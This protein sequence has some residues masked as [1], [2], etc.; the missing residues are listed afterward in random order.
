MSDPKTLLIVGGV[1]GGASAAARARR[2]S[3]SCR[4]VVFD[5]GPYVSFANCGLPYYVGDVIRDE[6][7][8]LVASEALFRNRFE[9]E[10][11]TRNEVVAIDREA[12][13]LTVREL[14]TGRE[15]TEPYDAL[16]LSPGAGAI[17]PPVPG[18][19]LPG[20]FV[21]RTIPDSRKIR[22][23][24]DDRSASRAVVV[25]GGLVGLEVAENLKHRGLEVTVLEM[26]P[27]ILPVVDPE[28]AAPMTK[29]LRDV[30]VDVR[31]GDG[32]QGIEQAGSALA[33]QTSSGKSIP[34][35]LVV[36]GVGVRPETT[37]AK[38][39]GLELGERGGIAVDERM[40]T[41]DPAIW[42]VGDAV[43]VTDFVT[44]Q[45]ILAPLAG[46]A[47]RQG[48]VAADVIFGRD[49]RFR[50]TQCTAVCGL[51]G[52]TV[53]STGATESR[54]R[55][56]GRADDL[57]VVY[58][59]PGHHVSYYP[60][61][62]RIHLKVL[63][64]RRD[65]KLLGAQAVGR[66]GVARRIDVIATALQL[67]GTV[68]DLAEAELCYAPQ[69]G[70]AKDPVNL[71]GMIATN[72]LNGDMPDARWAD[73]SDEVFLLDVR[74]EAEFAAVATPG[75]VNVPLEQLRQRLDELPRDRPVWVTCKVGQRAYYAVRLLLQRGVDAATLLG[76]LLTYEA[77]EAA[78]GSADC[79]V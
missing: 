15:Y 43:E 39:A 70:A 29:H 34:A 22:T 47:N 46:P 42:A 45:Q 28:M 51:F 1:A 31:L 9:I 58:L 75:S 79:P 78:A 73:L 60:G 14:E 53:A 35:D 48:R 3:E 13:Q 20:V 23:W 55:R 27:Q 25:G 50:G 65:G 56:E 38:A 69:F 37:L 77:F 62:K 5:R 71:A 7:K 67:G 10:V 36:L 66:E 21:L 18:V 64:D 49:S 44:G 40:Q 19:D 16:V 61:A 63:F 68:R 12:K 11:R 8:L 26:A 30:G 32:V 74:S 2:L 24:L 76:G 41:S 54:L 59:H 52:M 4:I 57:A 72:M 17:R 6:R 33:V